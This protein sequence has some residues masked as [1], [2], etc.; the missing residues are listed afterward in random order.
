MTEV[1][2]E[3]IVNPEQARILLLGHHDGV[4]KVLLRLIVVSNT[5]PLQVPVLAKQRRL[6][7]CKGQLETGI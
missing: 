1:F 3:C 5:L 6:A 7:M 2:G 4:L